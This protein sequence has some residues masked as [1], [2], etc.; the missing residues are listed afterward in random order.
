MFFKLSFFNVFRWPQ[1][2]VRYLGDRSFAH[3]GQRQSSL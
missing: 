1:M 3:K 2:C